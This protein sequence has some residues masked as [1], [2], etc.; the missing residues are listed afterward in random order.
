[1]CISIT[2]F[3]FNFPHSIPPTLCVLLSLLLVIFLSLFSLKTF[4]FTTHDG[5]YI[6]LSDLLK[7]SSSP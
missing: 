4:D 3:F 5:K 7:E 6:L 2:F 1:M